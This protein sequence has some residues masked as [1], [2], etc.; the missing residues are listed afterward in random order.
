MIMG[1]YINIVMSS[2]AH[3]EHNCGLEHTTGKNDKNN[4]I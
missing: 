1:L 3:T 4:L 2:C